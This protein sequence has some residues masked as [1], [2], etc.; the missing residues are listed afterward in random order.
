MVLWAEYVAVE[1]ELQV[2]QLP[3]VSDGKA[4]EANENTEPIATA[5]ATGTL[6][7]IWTL[8]IREPCLFNL[9]SEIYTSLQAQKMKTKLNKNTVQTSISQFLV[10]LEF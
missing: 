8:C 7:A 2:E 6:K 4:Y 3:H 1:G 5:W 10:K 9:I